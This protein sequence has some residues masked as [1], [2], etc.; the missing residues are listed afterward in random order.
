MNPLAKRSGQEQG[1]IVSALTPST[2]MQRHGHDEVNGKWRMLPM[3]GQKVA[4]R[5]RKCS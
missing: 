4:K 5:L 3:V 1:L 2:V